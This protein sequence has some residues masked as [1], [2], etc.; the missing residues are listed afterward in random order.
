MTNLLNVFAVEDQALEFK[1]RLVSEAFFYVA[2]ILLIGPFA[3]YIKS[4]L[5]VNVFMTARAQY[6]F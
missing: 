1:T 5:T 6:A 4:C 2:V 3:G